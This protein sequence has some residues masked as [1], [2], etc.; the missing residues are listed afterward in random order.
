MYGATPSERPWREHPGPMIAQGDWSK[1]VSAFQDAFAGTQQPVPG[2][3]VDG[4]CALIWYMEGGFQTAVDP[5]K[6]HL[7]RFKENVPRLVSPNAGGG[8]AGHPD[9]GTP[10]PDQGTQ[11]QDALELAYCQPYVGAFFNY[12][13]RDDADLRGWQSGVLWRDGTPKRSFPSFQRAIAEVGA[14][15]VDCSALKGGALPQP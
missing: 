9:A 15:E 11:I 8:E 14:D 13:L 1:L 5:A 2:R 3:C 7:Y 6:R 10:A 4:R 12:L